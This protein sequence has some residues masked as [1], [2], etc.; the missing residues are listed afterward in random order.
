MMRIVEV[1]GMPPAHM[2]NA[3]TKTKRF[4]TT[5]ELGEYVCRR[6]RDPKAVYR[7]PGSR[8]LTEVL[9]CNTG[10]PYGRRKDEA[11]H[12]PDDYGKFR[13]LILRML[14]YNPAK[15]LTASEAVRHNF[16]RKHSPNPTAALVSNDDLVNNPM[17]T[18]QQ[19]HQQRFGLQASGMDEYSKS[20]LSFAENNANVEELASIQRRAE[21]DEFVTDEAGN[22][23]QMS[24]TFIQPIGYN[25][26]PNNAYPATI[27]AI[28]IRSTAAVAASF[29]QQ[30]LGEMQSNAGAGV[31]GPTGGTD[32]FAVRGDDPNL[33]GDKEKSSFSRN[34]AYVMV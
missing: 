5:N 1:M 33:G 26:M 23:L 9:G 27:P 15:R 11:G 34:L 31:V 25:P 7:P 12:S 22:P 10:G 13:D 17:R 2:L 28:P 16:L 4:F 8:T 18:P 3:S 30:S 14:E 21:V 32:P 29:G 24:N 19:Q 6:S 20:R